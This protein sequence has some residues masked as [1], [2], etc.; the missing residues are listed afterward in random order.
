MIDGRRK[1]KCVAMDSGCCIVC[2]LFFLFVESIYRLSIRFRGETLL[3]SY[4]DFILISG[5]VLAVVKADFI[6]SWNLL[7]TT[8]IIVYA[9][10]DCARWKKETKIKLMALF[11]RD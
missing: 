3:N 10:V 7:F 8:L 9:L 1:A 11:F 5:G 6:V 2:A 4:F